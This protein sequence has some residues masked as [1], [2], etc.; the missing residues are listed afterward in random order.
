[1]ALDRSQLK[2]PTLPKKTIPFPLLG[3]EVIVRGLLL[4]EQL[5]N[6][7]RSATEREVREGE[8]EGEAKARA[9]GVMALRLLSQV[10]IDPEG[11]PLLSL[12]EWEALS[13]NNPVELMEFARV[14]S[15]FAIGGQ[16]VEKN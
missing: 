10:V 16:D 6:N 4:S 14:V 13:A 8:T 11:K 9:N 3:G 2:L 7:S 12:V 15:D 1:M 5:A